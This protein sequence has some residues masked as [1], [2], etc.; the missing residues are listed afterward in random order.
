MNFL[1]CL[2]VSLII[3]EIHSYTNVSTIQSTYWGGK[4]LDYGFKTFSLDNGDYVVLGDTFGNNF[5]S[6]V[7]TPVPQF[8]NCVLGI[9]SFYVSYHSGNGNCMWWSCVGGPG[10]TG[11]AS[12]SFSVDVVIDKDKY[13]YA[14]GYTKNNQLPKAKSAF[15]GGTD[16]V[17]IKFEPTGN[18][19]WTQYVGGY[20]SSSTGETVTAISMAYETINNSSGNYNMTSIWVLGRIGGAG[21]SFLWT[22]TCPQY[23]YTSTI[24]VRKYDTDGNIIYST[25]IGGGSVSSDGLI[26]DSVNQIILFTAIPDTSN[27][28]IPPFP[29]FPSP[30][31]YNSIPGQET[32]F[33]IGSVSWLGNLTNIQWMNIPGSPTGFTPLKLGYNVNNKTLYAMTAMSDKTILF[34]ANPNKNI[35]NLCNVSSIKANQMVVGTDGNIYMVGTTNGKLKLVNYVPTSPNRNTTSGMV[36]FNPNDDCKIFFSTFLTN[37]EMSSISYS[38]FQGGS[39]V[40]VGTSNGATPPNLPSVNTLQPNVAGNYDALIIRYKFQQYA[41]NTTNSSISTGS[42]G[43][44]TGSTGVITTGDSNGITT[45]N[46]STDNSSTTADED[47]FSFKITTSVS[48][49]FCAIFISFL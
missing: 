29:N 25:C 16:G 48:L 7:G 11:G 40:M 31:P 36:S 6:L 30:Y 35:T 4:S 23:S 9:R 19:S 10:A 38:T 27:Q 24:F 13:V 5:T 39:V 15:G 22:Q 28:G 47:S 1:L 34:S 21:V 17:L 42:T 14:S 49:I 43:I 37:H 12:D 32:K 2:L 33:V 18:L 8:N 45:S 26:V 46:G 20:G 3:A 44:T 41:S